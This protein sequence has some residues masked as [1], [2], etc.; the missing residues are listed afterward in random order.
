MTKRIRLVV[1]IF[2]L[3]TVMAVLP[4]PLAE[5]MPADDARA[6]HAARIL[7]E[8]VNASVQAYVTDQ[9]GRPITGATVNI[10]GTVLTGT[11]NASGLA[12]FSNLL[13]NDT[14]GTS[15]NLTAE[16]D[17]YNPSGVEQV[18]AFPNI[19]VD[20]HLVIQG[21]IILGTVTDGYT[22][23]TNATVS[24]PFLGFSNITIEDGTYRLAGV[25]ASTFPYTV[26]VTAEGY[27][28]QSKEVLVDIGYPSV[29]NFFMTSR[30]GTISG[31]I[32]HATTE[33]PLMDVNVSVRVGTVTVIVSTNESGT[34]TIPDLPAGIYTVSATIEGFEPASVTGIVVVSG[35][36]TVDVDFALVEKPTRLYGVVRA[37]TVLLPGVVIVV[38]GT[39]YIT[40]SSIYGDWEINN[41]TAGTYT[42]VASLEGYYTYTADDVE[43]PRGG[44]KQ[45]IISMEGLPGSVYGVVFSSE[46]RLT[47]SGVE[48]TLYDN[49]MLRTTIT[50]VNGEFQFTGISAGDYTIRF[51]LDEFKPREIGP[52]AMSPEAAVKLD[53]VM[54]EPIGETFGGFIFGFDLAH[55]MMILALLLTIVILA[56]AVILRIRSFE[57]PEKAPAVYDQ[58]EDLSEEE[59][60]P[61]EQYEDPPE[62]EEQ[63]ESPDIEPKKRRVREDSS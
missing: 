59:L 54:M 53:Q 8:S 28:N 49:V 35:A 21:G 18:L 44:E 60:E 9:A 5:L 31:M 57:E 61:E 37:G 16:K 47:L 3:A 34:Y 15:Y 48:V 50:N 17:G 51:V 27:I 22:P 45:L 38:V 39:E 23:I 58:D 19:T 30:T 7:G 29:L 32:T 14:S 43:I 25:P 52:I 42:I 33:E 56:V 12:L 24:I 6:P 46:T 20:V 11:T 41:I 13:G 40:N 62:T 36:D 55:S 63:D 2:C 1:A 10:V 4:A 26:T